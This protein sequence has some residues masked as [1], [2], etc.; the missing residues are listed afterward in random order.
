MHPPGKDQISPYPPWH[1]LITSS[2]WFSSFYFHRCTTFNPVSIILA[3]HTY[4]PCQSLHACISVPRNLTCDTDPCT[5]TF[6]LTA[7][8]VQRPTQHIIL[9]YFG[10]DRSSCNLN[11]N[12]S[13]MLLPRFETKRNPTYTNAFSFWVASRRLWLGR[14]HRS[15]VHRRIDDSIP[16]VNPTVS[17]PIPCRHGSSSSSLLLLLL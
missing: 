1:H 8:I 2:S 4:E 16:A 9:S 12:I 14:L 6:W 15:S 13:G 5:L 17:Y 3:F 10:D 11:N 7:S